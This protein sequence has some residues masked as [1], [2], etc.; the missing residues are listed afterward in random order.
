MGDV[1]TGGKRR[2]DQ[3][4]APGFAEGL[5]ELRTD[6]VRGRRDL[7]RAELEYLS[8]VRRLLQG[9]MDILRAEADRRERGGP[10]EPMVD[11]LAAILSDGPRGP[12]RGEVP[13]MALPEDEVA[14]ARRRVER[15]VG[16]ASV[17]NAGG[18]SDQDLAEALEKLGEE[19]GNISG[20][21]ARVI[22]VHDALQAE[23]KERLRSEMGQGS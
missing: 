17:S 8:L 1:Q 7:A 12:S 3:V 11:R 10:A 5:A 6:E 13:V 16:D 20:L 21:R 14:L 23:M 19:E 9:R 15:L 2:I 18:Q 4:L 22:D